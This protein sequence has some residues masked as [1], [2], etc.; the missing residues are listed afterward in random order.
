MNQ[1]SDSA[2]KFPDG[3]LWGAATSAHQV[4][5]GNIHNQWHAWEQQKNHVKNDE[6]SGKAADQYHRYAEDF[7]LAQDMHH[8]AH[9]LSIEWSRIE[10]VKGEWNDEAIEHYREV[11]QDLQQRDIRTM[12]TLF[13]FTL[14]NWAAEQGGFENVQTIDD[15]V[16]FAE[17]VAHELGDLIDFW[18]TINEPSVYT[19]MSYIYGI[20]PP[21]RYLAVFTGWRVLKNLARAHGLLYKKL[22][23][24]LDTTDSTVQVGIAKNM[25]DYALAPEYATFKNRL[26][27]KIRDYIWN[28]YFFALT[29][30][31]HD[32]IGINYYFHQRLRPK[33]FWQLE[34]TPTTEIPQIDT[35]D[36]GWELYPNGL[37]N[38]L[39]RLKTYHL[40]IYITEHGLADANDTHRPAYLIQ[41]LTKIHA[42]IEAGADVRG[43]FHW[44]LLDNFEWHEGF[45]PR[46]GL[47]AVDYTNFT[48]TPRLSSELYK[49]VIYSN[50]ISKGVFEQYE[51]NKTKKIKKKNTTTAANTLATRASSYITNRVDYFV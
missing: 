26:A 13:H 32:Y 6:V 43:Y 50:G 23:D 27:M 29:K 48:R 17:K 41:S 40:P 47:I 34:P 39:V 46:F 30:N 19:S 5:G 3:F 8:N 33:N 15:F 16:Q 24:T 36:L 42:A 11:L 37:Y 7:Q 14:P 10:P 21:Q 22:H 20:W 35:S 45:M 44:S 49:N 12:V 51:K 4:E 1:E 2:L 18:C 25:I 9:R 28:D 31:H 38:L